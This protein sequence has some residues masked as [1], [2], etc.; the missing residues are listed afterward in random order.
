M[1]SEGISRN[2]RS[3]NYEEIV[4]TVEP[5]N[6]NK[7]P[8]QAIALCAKPEYK[9]DKQTLA[10]QSL[11]PAFLTIPQDIQEGAAELNLKPEY[12]Q[13]LREHPTQEVSSYIMPV[14]KYH[15][16][17]SAILRFG[18]NLKTITRMQSWFLYKFSNSKGKSGT[19]KFIQNTTMVCFMFP[20]SVL[21]FVAYMTGMLPSP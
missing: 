11:L 18:F 21:G 14:A 7:D 15:F 8:V 5:Y 6:Q 12:Q 1:K 2:S 19:V 10:C 3:G 17:Y 13:W 4:V 16:A 9:L 20:G